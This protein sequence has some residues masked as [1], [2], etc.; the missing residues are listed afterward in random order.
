MPSRVFIELGSN[1]DAERY[2][3]RAAVALTR[4]GRVVDIS[5]VYR[6]KPYGP[7]EQPYFLNAAIE[8][9]TDTS[10]WELRR[11]LR[12]IEVELG[13]ERS[14]NKYAPRKIDLDLCLYDDRVIQEDGLEL[15]HPDLVERAYLAR[16]L[17]DLA[18]E[19]QHPVS[20]ETMRELA[21]RLDSEA[22]YQS[23]P[24]VRL[25]VLHALNDSGHAETQLDSS[26]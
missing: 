6:T 7:T 2:L 11:E 1:I 13:R 24:D 17:A 22:Q 8:L 18:P 15:P 20:G 10:P 25:E 16:S 12:K 21:A 23:R 9:R 14:D 5:Q 3:P 4:L 19:L 26:R